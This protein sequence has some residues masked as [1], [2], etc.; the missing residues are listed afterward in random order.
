M[1]Y[2]LIYVSSAVRA[3]TAAHLRELLVVCEKNNRRDQVSGMLLYKGGN[4]M[5]VLEGPESSVRDT[6]RRIRADVRHDGLITLME[7]PQALRQFPAWS[8]SFRD[9][10]SS[11]DQPAGYSAFLDTPLN[12]SEFTTAPG[13]AQELLKL[14]KDS[15]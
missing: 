3:F 9:L 4:F 5:Q 12:G 10:E 14:F 7:G 13:R 11:S 8:M 2:S 1:L 15:R 6:H